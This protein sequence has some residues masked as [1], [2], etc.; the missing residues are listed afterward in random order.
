M[1]HPHADTHVDRIGRFL[2]LTDP[3]TVSL[4]LDTRH[5]AYAAA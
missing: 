4:C 2:G 5:V 1:F 3:A